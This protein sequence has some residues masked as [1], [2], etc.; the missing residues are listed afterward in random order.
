MKS[1]VQRVLR[2]EVQVGG[3]AVGWIGRGLLV[4]VGVAAGDSVVQ[5]QKMAEKV[6]FLRI[7]A[8]D[9]GKLNRSVQDV[10]GGILAIPN[11]TLLADA[12]K[13]RRPAFSAA[14]GGTDAVKLFDAFVEAL[15]SLNVTVTSGIFGAD[16]AINS[17]ADGPVNVLMD[18]T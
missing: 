5:A 16:M 12:S 4:Y 14:A 3:R 7:F 18:V 9:A 1:V 10:R 6:A 15:Q 17:V 2:A 13:G 11:F 8:D